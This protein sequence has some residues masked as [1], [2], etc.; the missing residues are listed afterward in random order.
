M[1]LNMKLEKSQMKNLRKDPKLEKIINQIKTFIGNYLSKYEEIENIILFGSLASGRFNEN[2]DIDI[3]ILFKPSTPKSMETA[4]FNYFLNLGKELDRSIQCI[5]FFPEDIKN[6]DTIFVE[7]IL[8][9]G[10][11]L[12]GN[13]NYFT[14]LIKALEFK[15]YQIITLNLRALNSSAKMKLKRILY[16]YKTSKKYSEKIYRYQKRGLVKELQGIKL[17]R[18][19]FIIPEKFLLF[20][21]NKLKE[22]D[23]KF[24]NFRVW[25]QEI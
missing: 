24:S 13:S 12:F 10:Q 11:L 2:S 21:E 7:N 18:G 5:F 19:S 15:P 6:W 17:G 8:A 25:M 14:T 20:V 16:G 23:I 3:C 9:E 22:F 4:I 1:S